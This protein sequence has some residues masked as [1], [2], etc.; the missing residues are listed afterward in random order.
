MITNNFRI[1][2]F[3]IV[4]QLFGQRFRNIV[5]PTKMIKLDL[6]WQLYKM[7]GMSIAGWW[8]DASSEE[9]TYSTM[10]RYTFAFTV[11]IIRTNEP[12]P[13]D[14]WK[15]P[16][17]YNV[18]FSKFGKLFNTFRQRWA[19]RTLQSPFLFLWSGSAATS[20]F[21]KQQR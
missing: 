8:G 16:P 14:R 20:E 9:V 6:K 1:R 10:S 4:Q 11:Q 2:S 21:M 18:S 12:T 7:H 5:S 3:E 19:E 17:N 15:H 13:L